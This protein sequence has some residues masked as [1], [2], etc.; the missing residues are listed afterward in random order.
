MTRKPTHPGTVFRE[1]VLKPL[2]ISVTD[3]AKLLGITRKALS[4]FVN[5]RSALSPEM[6]VRIGLA[7]NTSPESWMEMQVKLTMW[8]ARQKE[9][10]NVQVKSMVAIV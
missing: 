5:G 8:E 10:D 3:A 1:D 4:E 6:A 9:P 7:T 2:N